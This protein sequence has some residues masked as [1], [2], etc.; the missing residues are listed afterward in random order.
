MNR[1]GDWM[2]TYSGKQF[3]PLD[4]SADEVCIEDIAHSLALQCRFAGHCRSFYSVAQH[5]ALVSHEAEAIVRERQE[6]LKKPDAEVLRMVALMG[7]LHDASE[8]Y[9]VDVPR[10]VKPHLNGYRAFEDG[11]MFA[12]CERFGMAYENNLLWH[13]VKEA[14]NVLLATEARDLMKP[15]P[16]PWAPMPPPRAE[17][18]DPWA[19]EKAR[20]IFLQRFADLT[21]WAR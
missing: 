17:F 13:D 15:P 18:I 19:P 16:V 1:K 14:D 10:P 9:L 11:V 4:P 7:L 3:W 2:Q 20:S 12:V 21:G 8:A 6:I 5:S